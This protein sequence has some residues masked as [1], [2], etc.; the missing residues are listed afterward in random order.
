MV[1]KGSVQPPRRPQRT[2]NGSVDRMAFEAGGRPLDHRH[3]VDADSLEGSVKTVPACQR[4]RR[5]WARYCLGAI[6]RT[7]QRPE[8]LFLLLC[9]SS[10][11]SPVLFVGFVIRKKLTDQSMAKTL[12]HCYVRAVGDGNTCGC[13]DTRGD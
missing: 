11:A 1:P 8:I 4:S 13:V 2:R 7:S 12:L 10:P 9:F 6:R 3:E 5:Q